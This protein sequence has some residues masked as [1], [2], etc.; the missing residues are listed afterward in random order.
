MSQEGLKECCV[1]GHLHEG[2]PNGK[3]ERLYGLSTY[4]TGSGDKTVVIITD[5]FGYELPNGRL[6]A[7]EIATQGEYRVLVPDFF[8]GDSMDSRILENME[9]KNKSI[10]KKVT[11]TA[12]MLASGAPWMFRHREAAARPVVEGFMKQLRQDEAVKKVGAVGFCWGGR[13]SILLAQT[14]LVDASVACHP[15]L[16]SVP[17]DYKAVKKPLCICVGDNDDMFKGKDLTKTNDYFKNERKD[18]E[19]E[20]LVIPGAKHGYAIRG[21]P[22]DPEQKKQKD[23]ST[24]KTVSWFKAHL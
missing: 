1:S 15:S 19:F 5:V 7:D 4:V 13:W 3:V 10:V 23:Q 12:G 14:D 9:A 2:T 8:Q 18:V 24:A 22:R 16:L 21:D 11:D 6:L 20:M 17:A